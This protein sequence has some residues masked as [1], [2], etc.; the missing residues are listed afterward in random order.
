MELYKLVFFTKLKQ[1]NQRAYLG[2]AFHGINFVCLL[3]IIELFLFL[4]ETVF[5]LKAVC[6]ALQVVNQR[7]RSDC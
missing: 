1:L 4:S 2:G 3:D 5:S 6:A 7:E